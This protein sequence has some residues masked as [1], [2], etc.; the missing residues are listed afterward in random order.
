[1]RSKHVIKTLTPTSVSV[2]L[3]TPKTKFEVIAP[4]DVG[5]NY[6]LSEDDLIAT[7]FP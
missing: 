1:M 5:D 3:K 6:I 4:K 2:P 7:N